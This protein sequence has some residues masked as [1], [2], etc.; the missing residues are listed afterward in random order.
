M[1]K[2]GRA[3]ADTDAD[4][5]PPARRADAEFGLGTIVQGGIPVTPPIAGK[6]A[7]AEPS[8]QFAGSSDSRAGESKPKSDSP[9]PVQLAPQG[10]GGGLAGNT[11]TFARSLDRRTNLADDQKQSLAEVR[12]IDRPTADAPAGMA[13]AE[14]ASI[15][16]KALDKTAEE[17]STLYFDKEEKTLRED[18]GAIVVPDPASR[19]SGISKSAGGRWDLGGANTYTGGSTVTGGDVVVDERA[20]RFTKESAGR[21]DLNGATDFITGGTTINGGVTAGSSGI[22]KSG[23]GTLTFSGAGSTNSYGGVIA[24]NAPAPTLNK[25]AAGALDRSGSTT[26]VTGGIVRGTLHLGGKAQESVESFEYDGSGPA[27]LPELQN[28]RAKEKANKGFVVADGLSEVAKL[29]KP[30]PE[31]DLK[32]LRDVELTVAQKP[33]GPAPEPQPEIATS[34]NAFSTFS[35]NVSDVA[36]KLAAASLEQGKMPELATVRSEE[37]INAFDYRD[38]EPAAGA[39]LAFTTERARYPVRAKSR[40]APALGEDRRR[41]P[42][43]GTPAESR[44]AARQLRL[45]GARRSRAHPPANRCACSPRNC[46]RRTS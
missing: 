13:G 14:G 18:F 39:P 9:A 20:S 23:N 2:S 30:K 25:D 31:E 1:T 34:A 33:S 15:A 16:S 17:R 45:D 35:L 5:E 41:G 19:T 42:P 3:V 24:G 8:S 37:F 29:E 43:A 11:T 7:S 27:R 26:T 38:P 28:V 22:A 46:S 12:D 21:L 40:S 10:G 44:A 4:V 6:P 36:F 32:K